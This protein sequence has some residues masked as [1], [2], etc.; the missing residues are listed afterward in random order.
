MTPPQ[1]TIW[2]HLVVLIVLAGGF[3]SLVVYPFVLDD[4]VKGAIIGFMGLALQWEFGTAIQAATA[5]Q[6]QNATDSGAAAGAMVPTTTVSA[7]PP[8]TVTTTPP[9]PN[10][11]P[12]EEDLP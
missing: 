11:A 10:G 9:A 4:L 7:G 3:Y 5:R 2:G 6:Q 12:D 1:Q 8:V